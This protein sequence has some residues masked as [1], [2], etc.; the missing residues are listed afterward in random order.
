MQSQNQQ[1]LL[2]GSLLSDPQKLKQASSRVDEPVGPTGAQPWTVWG[3]VGHGSQRA[4][5]RDDI[6]A[7]VCWAG[8]RQ[9]WCRTQEREG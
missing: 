7:G 9:R 2:Q 6:E 5:R 4:N 1:P 3:L 8:C